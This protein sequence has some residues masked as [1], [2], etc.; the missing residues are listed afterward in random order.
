MATYYLHTFYSRLSSAFGWRYVAAV[1]MTYAANQSAAEYIF[2]QCRQFWLMDEVGLNAAEF[3]QIIGFSRLP[4]QAKAIFG[5]ASDAFPIG[6]LHRA[7]YMLICASVGAIAAALMAYLPGT[8][9]SPTGALLLCMGIYFGVAGVDVQI[10]ATICEKSRDRPDLAGDMQSLAW[11]TLATCSVPVAI[12]IAFGLQTVGVHPLFLV[13]ALC[14]LATTVAPSRGWLGEPKGAT[15]EMFARCSSMLRH[16]QKRLV[17]LAAGLIS[18]YSL[19]LGLF[20]MACGSG[21][22]EVA[23]SVTIAGNFVFSALLYA[24]LSGVDP[25]L[26]RAALFAFL[27]SALFPSTNVVFEWAHAPA[28]GSN[29]SR[30]YTSEMCKAELLSEGELLRAQQQLQPPQ[31]TG[32]QAG[33]QAGQ[34]L[35]PCG[36]ARAADLPCLSPFVLTLLDVVA[37]IGAA[38]AAYSYARS[39]QYWRYRSFIAASQL[40]L[41]V[42]NFI[43]LA[44]VLRLNRPLDLSDA[45]FY[46]GD[47]TLSSIVDRLNLIPVL[48]FSAKLCPCAVEASMF[49]VFMG[50]SN[51]GNDASLYL[52]SGV[53]R[54]MGGVEAPGFA[55]LPEYIAVR[56]LARLLP[57]LLI[58]YLVPD[59]TPAETA[60]AMGAGI[61]VTGDGE[62]TADTSSPTREQEG[63][64]GG[65][66]AATKKKPPKGSGAGGAEALL[67]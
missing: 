63:G 55:N 44:W 15:L 49:A 25:C 3:G 38:A 4:A 1:V 6:G 60:E 54:L 35:L 27:R 51:L 24:V 31:A 32:E 67:L 46:F 41:V 57:M 26:A 7:P 14:F 12:F 8:S 56:S 18:I 58:P 48:V 11:G 36:W 64:A 34:H 9:I 28:A 5:L 30:C 65:S 61:G 16:P 10:D 50:L 23:A 59:G 29:D 40:A 2:M 20:Q 66:A 21:S 43:D 47:A 33:V 17:A 37:M 13:T 19:S 42:V 39:F 62:E 45:L 52:G 53:L 22:S